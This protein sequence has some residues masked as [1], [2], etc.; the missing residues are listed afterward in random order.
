MAEA[1]LAIAAVTAVVGTVATV[2]GTVVQGRAQREAGE[3]E[4]AAAN[5]E[6]DQL[7]RSAKEELAAGQR[8]GMEIGRQT[9]LARSRQRALAA[10][11]G[12]GAGDVSVQMLEADLQR[13]G[14]YRRDLAI[15]GGIERAKG[16][17]AQATARRKAGRAALTGSRMAAAGTIISGLG[18]AAN[19][20]SSFFLNYGAGR[21][22]STAAAGGHFYG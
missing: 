3:Q 5:Y 12:A 1:A 2:A 21:P 6:A 22:T 14:N 13:Q 20:A 8:E 18:S 11:S 17:V 4:Q 7:E 9:G 16:Q 10:A 15:Y 19:T